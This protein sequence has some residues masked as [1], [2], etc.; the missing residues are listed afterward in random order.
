MLWSIA[1]FFVKIVIEH[2]CIENQ[3]QCGKRGRILSVKVLIP[4]H[5]KSLY[6][7]AR[8]AKHSQSLTLLSSR[9]FIDDASLKK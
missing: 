1:Q 2:H 9:F 5:A 3:L 8:Q 6:W 7:P 4:F